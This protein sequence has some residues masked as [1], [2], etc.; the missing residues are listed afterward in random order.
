MSSSGI[1]LL[2]VLVMRISFQNCRTINKNK[3]S[4][5]NEKLSINSIIFLSEVDNFNLSY[6][7]EKLYQY[8]FDKTNRRIGV[9]ARNSVD[10]IVW[11][12]IRSEVTFYVPVVF[13]QVYS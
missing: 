3:V 10:I 4:L 9:I 6:V 11:T 5:F 2:L 13:T 7:Q 8:H 1:F 12:E